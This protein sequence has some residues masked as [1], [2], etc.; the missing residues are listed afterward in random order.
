MIKTFHLLYIIFF[1]TYS[2]TGIGIPSREVY[3]TFWGPSEVSRKRSTRKLDTIWVQSSK[4]LGENQC[5]MR[6]KTVHN[7]IF[8]GKNFNHIRH[9]RASKNPCLDHIMKF[10]SRYYL[11]WW[12]HKTQLCRILRP[13]KKSWLICT[14]LLIV[15]LIEEG[16]SW[17]ICILTSSMSTKLP[18]VGVT[19]AFW[20]HLKTCQGTVGRMWIR[21]EGP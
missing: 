9:P 18:V 2:F 19:L 8:R 16:R 21:G 4:I 7:K 3:S 15:T 13:S 17:R 6:L 20:L 12:N 1:I 10:H 11:S 5:W 14:P